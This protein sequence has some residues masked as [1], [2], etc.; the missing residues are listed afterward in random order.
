[1]A[2]E[3]KV[4]RRCGRM[5]QWSDEAIDSYWELVCKCGHSETPDEP[6]KVYDCPVHGKIGYDDFCP[7][8]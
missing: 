2:N 4:C 6:V 7:K 1:V 5:G 3:H 8:C